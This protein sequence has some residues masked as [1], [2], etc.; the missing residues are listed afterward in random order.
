MVRVGPA[1]VLIDKARAP[2]RLRW[3]GR[4]RDTDGH[5][6]DSDRRRPCVDLGRG[7][8][9]RRPRR[10][11]CCVAGET[12]LLHWK[13]LAVLLLLLLLHRDLVQRGHVFSLGRR[14][15]Q[16]MVVDVSP[17]HQSRPL[18]QRLP[19][20]RDLP[21]DAREAATFRGCI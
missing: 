13:M 12:V 8:G 3:L 15:V 9:R 1:V 4:R 2:R 17:E 11:S 18:S 10:C 7:V 5:T 6:R 21:S 14:M 20:R 16:R 19:S